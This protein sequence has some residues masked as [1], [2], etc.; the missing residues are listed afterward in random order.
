MKI[1]GQ[2][3]LW[4]LCIVMLCCVSCKSEKQNLREKLDA[5]YEKETKTLQQKSEAIKIRLKVLL[6]QHA[7][8]IKLHQESDVLLDNIE[9][10]EKEMGTQKNH[11]EQETIQEKTIHTAQIL[12]DEFK[13]RH[14]EH[15]EMEA[16]HDGATE[17]E[18]RA[19]HEQFETDLKKYT[20]AFKKAE[21]NLLIAEQQMQ[22]IV[23][24]NNALLKKYNR[25]TIKK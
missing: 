17:A 19:E 1:L 13:K 15:E 16:N 20:I 11:T 8:L 14:D 25:E 9:L 22:F 4:A 2:L 10:T 6:T 12:I 5:E 23:K 18:I 21:N 3:V 7:A 24:E